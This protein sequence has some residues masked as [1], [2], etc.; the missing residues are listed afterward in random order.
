MTTPEARSRSC[1]DG[2]RA[3]LGI[4]QRTGTLV[5]AP[6]SNY[7]HSSS[8]EDGLPRLFEMLRDIRSCT[9]DLQKRITRIES[10][11]RSDVAIR[12][13]R[14][15]Q[16]EQWRQEVRIEVKEIR[17]DLDDI[18]RNKSTG[19]GAGDGLMI[20]WHWVAVTC[21]VLGGL[22]YTLLKKSGA[23]E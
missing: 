14:D 19:T 6:T 12:A 11:V 4:D 23:I 20:P 10:D 5:V 2:S 1:L 7:P 13:E 22:I 17:R 18:R 8:A 9:D 21:L 3:V 16:T 15:R